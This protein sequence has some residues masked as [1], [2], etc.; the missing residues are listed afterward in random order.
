[1]KMVMKKKLKNIFEGHWA[2]AD[3][4]AAALIVKDIWIVWM[5]IG[6]LT[7]TT[8]TKCKIDGKLK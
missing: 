3:A 7:Y 2:A 4:A 5:V 6:C 1:M 8:Q